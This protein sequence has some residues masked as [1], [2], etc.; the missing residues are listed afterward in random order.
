[1]LPS[2]LLTGLLL[3]ACA[4]DLKAFRIP[5]AISLAVI[6]LFLIKALAMVDSMVWTGH[7]LAF[8]L[9]FVL[10][11]AAFTFG[12]I[13]GGDVKLLSA[14]A[15]WFGISA[16][17]SLLT[18]TAIGGG[19]FAV[20]LLL[21]RHGASRLLAVASPEGAA[22]ATG[23]LDRKAPMPYALPIAAAALWLEWQ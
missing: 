5:N 17:P 3:V 22:R 15:L 6:V 13:G 20:L 7:A 16:L 12:L 18:L 19:L 11:F 2:L 4:F 8:A 10:G 14:L 21:L 1:M 9:M 23:L